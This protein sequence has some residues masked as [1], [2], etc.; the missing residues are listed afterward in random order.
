[1][2]GEESVLQVAPEFRRAA[3]RVRKLALLLLAYFL[4]LQVHYH[5]AIT[6]R[7]AYLGFTD[8]F[9]LLKFGA[10]LLI[11]FS[12]GNLLREDARP[13]T[14]FLNVLAALVVV[15]SAVIYGGSDL[16]TG[17]L[18]LVLG[19]FA[20]VWL[21]S[22]LVSVKRVRLRSIS[23]GIVMWLLAGLAGGTLGGIVAI[24][25]TQFF[26][27]NISSVYEIRGDAAEA[28]PGIFGYLNSISTKVLI[29][30]G[31]VLA[32]VE[33]RWILMA[34]FSCLSVLFFAFTAHKSPL[35]YP[36]VV[37]FIY[38][39]AKSRAAGRGVLAGLVFF[40]VIALLDH[41]YFERHG[42][43]W[44]GWF[45]SLFARRAILV[46]SL[47]NWQ[48]FD[49]F[50]DADRF[51]WASSKISFGLIEAP[52]N[53]N[54]PRLIGVTYSN[55]IERFANAG[56]IGSGFANAGAL[57]VLVYSVLVGALLAFLD[58][59][60]KKIGSRVTIALFALPVVTI[61]VSSDLVSS[62]LTHGLL[63]ALFLLM[64]F[65][66]YGRSG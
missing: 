47:I 38:W 64:L 65:P 40:M 45:S 17:Y 7:Y 9:S 5:Y 4:V 55:N 50:V 13:S 20:M 18:I 30:F 34:V 44:S 61:F 16:S 21:S 1:M 35:F 28:V 29:P 56:W 49:F 26:N 11:V 63:A 58:E 48:Y 3:L 12:V 24:S 32:L 2:S 39:V 43:W 22:R 46:P 33:R 54:A 60:S 27:L 59:Y 19:A 25:G 51:Y 31:L 53:L 36:T 41:W 15:P 14:F 6:S 37:L 8:N 42:A 10:S 52:Y 23:S 66:A 62:L 57:G